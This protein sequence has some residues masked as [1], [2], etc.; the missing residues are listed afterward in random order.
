MDLRLLEKTLSVMKMKQ[1]EVNSQLVLLAR[2]FRGLSQEDLAVKANVTQSAVSQLEKGNSVAIGQDKLTKI[3]E[4]LEFPERFF[5][6]DEP[7]LS[8]G[9]SSYFYRKKITKASERNFVSGIV[10]L[11]RM[12]LSTMLT[13]VEVESTNPLPKETVNEDNN[14]SQIAQTVRDIWGIPDG[15]VQNLT[16]YVEKAGIVIVECPFG[17]DKIDGTSVNYNNLPPIIFINNSLPPD[18]YRFTLA[19]ELGHIVMHDIPHERME[20]E[21]DAFASSLL[22]PSKDFLRS[23]AS[24]SAGRVNIQ[25][26]IKLKPLWKT[27]IASMIVR[28]HD[29]GRISDSEYRNMYIS[30]SKMKLNRNDPQPFRK[31][32]PALFPQIVEACLG[33]YRFAKNNAESILGIYSDDFKL[34]YGALLPEPKLKIVSRA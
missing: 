30:L 24:S 26:L 18:R 22:M 28:L 6:S 34:L 11:F 20:E 7:R 1:Q 5:Y 19:H 31:E 25:Q 9:S 17:T 3:F 2:E 15:P 29:T 4:A 23:I 27:S 33:D 10:N 12:H 13:I 32:R 16:H 8:F 14:P 21:A